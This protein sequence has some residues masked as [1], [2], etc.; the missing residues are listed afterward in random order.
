[1]RVTVCRRSQLIQKIPTDK[2]PKYFQPTPRKILWWT[3]IHRRMDSTVFLRPE[4]SLSLRVSLIG[5]LLLSHCGMEE[6]EI[7]QK[8]TKERFKIMKME[9]TCESRLS[10]RATR[11]TQSDLSQLRV[12]P[13]AAATNS[14]NEDSLLGH[15]HVDELVVVDEAIAVNVCLADHLV[16]LLQHTGKARA[17]MV[18]PADRKPAAQ[19]RAAL[20]LRKTNAPHRSASRPGWS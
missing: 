8:N 15:H 12:L 9:T 3:K 6:T 5:E 18:K 16:D 2:H 4:T 20:I 14:T 13:S 1:M 17:A 10:R 19:D 7:H 11:Q